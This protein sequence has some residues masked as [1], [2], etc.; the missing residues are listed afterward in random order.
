MVNCNFL[1]K[2]VNHNSS[3]YE[4]LRINLIWCCCI[5][6]DKIYKSQE[7]YKQ[8]LFNKIQSWPIY[9]AMFISTNKNNNEN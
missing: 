1:L 2:I 5:Y 7:Q 3:S 9:L 4:P 8:K 6:C